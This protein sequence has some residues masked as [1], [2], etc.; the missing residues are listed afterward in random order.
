M[1]AAMIVWKKMKKRLLIHRLKAKQL[2]QSIHWESGLSKHS[3]DN[4][5]VLDLVFELTI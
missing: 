4:I 2:E 5:A 3:E 1:N